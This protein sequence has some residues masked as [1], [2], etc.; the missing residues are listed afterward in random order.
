MASRS[1]RKN[2]FT[3]TGFHAHSAAA[4]A[5][6]LAVALVPATILLLPAQTAGPRK[7]PCPLWW[8]SMHPVL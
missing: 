6:L 5:L 7:N 2:L 4:A 1:P 3:R 8:C